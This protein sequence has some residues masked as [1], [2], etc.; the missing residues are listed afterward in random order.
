MQ[1][2]KKNTKKNKQTKNKTKKYNRFET[3]FILKIRAALGTCSR[4]SV[5]DTTAALCKTMTMGTKT[6]L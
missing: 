1:N 4:L 5:E 6:Y 3:V 2:K